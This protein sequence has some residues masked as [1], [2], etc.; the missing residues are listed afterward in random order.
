MIPLP[1]LFETTIPVVAS[2]EPIA[3]DLHLWKDR[4]SPVLF[5]VGLSGSG[6]T[7]LTKMLMKPDVKVIHLD[8]FFI[9]T[10]E[11][12]GVNAW[13]PKETDKLDKV[14]WSKYFNKLLKTVYDAASGK[15]GK[16]VIIEGIQP[17]DIWSIEGEEKMMKFFSKYPFIFMNTSLIMSTIRSAQRESKDPHI[18]K[19]IIWH[20]YDRLR[21]NL[22]LK[23]R[24]D[25]F[26]KER[27]KLSDD[28]VVVK[29]VQ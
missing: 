18:K 14:F 26:R 16:R 23:R 12:Y 9:E 7:T 17:V 6:K 2:E 15:L 29:V 24:I 25:K 19:S 8:N 27:I 3:T 4:T 5:V 28:V 1:I 21:I 22:N 10:C 13:D 11:E 20:A